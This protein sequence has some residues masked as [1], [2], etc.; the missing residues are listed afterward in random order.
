MCSPYGGSANK[1]REHSLVCVA[2]QRKPGSSLICVV[3][4]KG[5]DEV[6][7]GRGF[8]GE[9]NGRRALWERR[10]RSSRLRRDARFTVGSRLDSLGS[11]RLTGER[12][13]LQTLENSCFWACRLPIAASPVYPTWAQVDDQLAQ[14]LFS[15]SLF[16]IYA[17]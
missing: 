8:M 11:I 5:T 2:E 4:S 14:L 7:G 15:R 13:Q 16:G 17:V 6:R 1:F 10:R 3:S 9:T 12:S